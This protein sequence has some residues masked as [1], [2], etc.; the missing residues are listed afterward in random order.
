MT[1]VRTRRGAHSESPS[2][3]TI[4]TAFR[5]SHLTAKFDVRSSLP[6]IRDTDSRALAFGIRRDE[7]LSVE[8][9]CGTGADDTRST[10]TTRDGDTVSIVQFDSNLD[11]G[12][13]TLVGDCE[14]YASEAVSDGLDVGFDATLVVER[15]SVYG[16]VTTLVT[17][18]AEESLRDVFVEAFS[19][20]T[21]FEESPNWVQVGSEVARDGGTVRRIRLQPEVVGDERIELVREV[22]PVHIGV[23]S[24]FGVEVDQRRQWC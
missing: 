21:C 2:S 11:F 9:L 8:Y 4:V 3:K 18:V 16:D 22:P 6:W 23:R 12:G 20:G 24:E 15:D 14:L 19:L 13:F 7:D 17:D 1:N 10:G 5:S